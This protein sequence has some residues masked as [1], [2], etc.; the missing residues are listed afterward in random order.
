MD[1]I[2]NNRIKR[3]KFEMNVKDECVARENSRERVWVFHER[4]I[5]AGFKIVTMILDATVWSQLSRS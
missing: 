1:V 5:E 3:T 2:A 4:K